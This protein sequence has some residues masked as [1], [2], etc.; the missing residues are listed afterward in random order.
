MRRILLCLMA[1]MVVGCAPP[2][3]ISEGADGE[4]IVRELQS[5][6]AGRHPLGLIRGDAIAGGCRVV[7]VGEAGGCLRYEG[8]KCGYT[9]AGCE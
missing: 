8:E 1:L 4:I 7:V 3:A 5:N 2:P 9:S 6:A